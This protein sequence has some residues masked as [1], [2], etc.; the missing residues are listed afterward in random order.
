MA[1]SAYPHGFSTTLYE[2]DYG[3]QRRHQPGGRG[4]TG[5]DRDHARVKVASTVTAWQAVMTGAPSGRGTGRSTTGW[6][7]PARTSSAYGGALGS[8]NAKRGNGTPPTT[9]RPSVDSLVNAGIATSDPASASPSTPA[10]I[11]QPAGQ[12]ALRR[13]V[14]AEHQHRAV[15]QVHLEATS[16]RGTGTA[17]TRSVSGPHN[18]RIAAR[19]RS[20][21]FLRAEQQAEGL[22]QECIERKRITPGE[23]NENPIASHSGNGLQPSLYSSG[24]GACG[25]SARASERRHRLRGGRDRSRQL[26]VGETGT[27]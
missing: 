21:T 27:G 5:Q 26:T 19:T 22:A 16:T 11:K 13:P 2:Y 25:S 20:G 23:I 17:R 12:R 14:P 24:L 6:C 18:R 8:W 3:T 15:Q 10:L 4:R 1:Q 9:P 7:L